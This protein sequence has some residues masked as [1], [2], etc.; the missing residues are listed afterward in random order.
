MSEQPQNDPL[1]S[2][3]DQKEQVMIDS[4]FTTVTQMFP[5]HLTSTA[6]IL[7]KIKDVNNVFFIILLAG[8]REIGLTQIKRLVTPHKHCLRQFK[9]QQDMETLSVG[10]EISFFRT[11]YKEKRNILGFQAPKELE[12][13][14][15]LPNLSKTK[16]HPDDQARAAELIKQFC[17]VEEN[18]SGNIKVTVRLLEEEYELVFSNLKD[19]HSGFIASYISLFED[20]GLKMRFSATPFEV[21]M[22]VRK[23]RFKTKKR[24]S[25]TED[26]STK[27]VR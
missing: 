25:D 1:L 23:S 10:I 6:P 16:L 9:I 12:F 3:L 17:F 27:R 4:L 26:R 11:E 21:V 24:K 20:V 14:D 19:I 2:L 15:F 18:T 22:N 5:N 8:F 13:A 7:H